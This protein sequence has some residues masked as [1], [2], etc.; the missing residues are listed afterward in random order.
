L[1]LGSLLPREFQSAFTAKAWKSF[2]DLR[3][4]RQSTVSINLDVRNPEVLR[5]LSTD[6]FSITSSNMQQ[7]M[8]KRWSMRLHRHV[9]VSA[10]LCRSTMPILSRSLLAQEHR[11]QR[12]LQLRWHQRWHD[13]HAVLSS[14]NQ[15]RVPTGSS[16][17]L[18]FRDWTV[19][20]STSAKLRLW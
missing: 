5:S 16:V 6:L 2:T 11:V 10:E 4:N 15:L 18:H 17:H 9:P 1:P 3:T 19:H 8:P 14:W 12:R 7:T 20:S 13:M